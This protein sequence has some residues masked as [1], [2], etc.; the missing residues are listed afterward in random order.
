MTIIA[1]ANAALALE[2]ERTR[3]GVGCAWT[4]P[5]PFQ[6]LRDRLAYLDAYIRAD[7]QTAV[8]IVLKAKHANRALYFIGNGGSA[9]IAS[10]MAADF[11]K[12]GGMKAQCFTEGPLLTCVSNDI[13]Y[14]KVFSI[15]LVRH[16]QKDD[17]LVAISSSGKS[18]NITWAVEKGIELGMKVITLSGFTPENQLRTLGG[19]VNFYV[20][21]DRYGTVEICH[22]AICH[23]I[24][25]AVISH[26]E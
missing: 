2:L 5:A 11:L 15:P 25:D 18:L 9:A 21:S 8:N 13:G 20:P 10:H 14:Q 19:D 26:A 7:L 3:N 12:N 1:D 17:V 16:A 24:L 23:A 6:L 22:H 4:D